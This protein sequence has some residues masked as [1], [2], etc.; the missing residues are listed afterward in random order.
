MRYTT[1]QV[2]DAIEVLATAMDDK[3]LRESTEPGEMSITIRPTDSAYGN[4]VT[5]PDSGIMGTG[6]DEIAD[7]LL[8]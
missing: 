3:L 5:D 7:Y 2:L 8:H 4:D 1:K 6:N